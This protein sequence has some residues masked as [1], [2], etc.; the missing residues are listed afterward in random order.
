MTKLTELAISLGLQSRHLSA[1]GNPSMFAAHVIFAPNVDSAVKLGLLRSAGTLALLY[2]PVDE[3]FGIVPLEAMAC[4]VP[5]LACNSGGPLETVGHDGS[6]GLLRP[7]DAD[8]WAAAIGEM[9]D[10][11]A[12]QRLVM[13]ERAKGRVAETFSLDAMAKHLETALR[14]AA[15]MGDVWADPLIRVGLAIGTAAIAVLIALVY[16]HARG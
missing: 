4:G 7:P 15:A 11:S 2:T 10:L 12:A 16:T 5:V 3:H 14:E 1:I 9:V 8:A 13:A 6:V